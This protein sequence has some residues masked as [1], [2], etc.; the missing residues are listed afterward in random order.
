MEPIDTKKHAHLLSVPVIKFRK[1]R[2]LVKV[3]T[4]SVFQRISLVRR[5]ASCYALE[6]NQEAFDGEL[7]EQDLAFLIVAPCSERNGSVQV[8]GVAVFSRI[9]RSRQWRLKW[10]W[11]HLLCRKRGLVALAVE[12]LESKYGQ[13]ATEQGPIVSRRI[14]AQ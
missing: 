4:R 14:S 11:L 9:G 10:H 3:T 1:A 5:L 2:P 13:L 8:L 12:H 6:N 7:A